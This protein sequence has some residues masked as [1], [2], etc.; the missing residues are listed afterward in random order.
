MS[1]DVYSHTE[2]VNEIWAFG[3]QDDGG[4]FEVLRIIIAYLNSALPL[5]ILAE[6]DLGRV[7]FT[8]GHHWK[9]MRSAK[10]VFTL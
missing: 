7:S 8:V 5:E 9:V 1:L 2:K 6:L 10:A 3:V 4:G